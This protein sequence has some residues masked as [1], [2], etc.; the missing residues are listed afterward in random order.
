MAP[1]ALVLV[2]VAIG[3]VQV[4]AALATT[5]FD[6]A[7]AT[8]TVLIRVAVAAV[9]L[10]AIWR[11]RVRGLSRGE[12]KLLGAF[13]ATFALMNLTFYEAIA[14]I[15]LGLAVTLEFVGPLGVAV[16][17]SRR[18]RDLLWV[19][20][21]GGGILLIASPGS[22]ALD[23]LGMALA[24]VAGVCWGTYIVLS[25][26]T[27]QAFPRGSGLAIA[28][29]V[30]AVLLAPVGVASAGSALLDAKLLALGA[31]VAVL[32]SLI[33]YSLEFEALRMMPERVFGI[34]MSVEPA[35]AA[36]V[37]FV[38]LEQALGTRE[39]AG[40]VAVTAAVCGAVAGTRA[41]PPRD[42]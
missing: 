30:A 32:S 42:A 27:G 10:A 1:R 9:L 20:L 38:V 24:L 11:P 23:P 29:C 41:P 2:F 33:P 22:G 8:G 6:E 26:R 7:G 4:G 25:A 15:P 18:A 40:I 3:S 21:A 16:A 34:L 13:G 17:G 31:G 12:W 19:A 37:G 39:L 28:M 5:L 14:R 36:L 35:V